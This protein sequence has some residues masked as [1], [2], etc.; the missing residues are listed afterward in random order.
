M[1]RA[2]LRLVERIEEPTGAVHKPPT[3]YS[4]IVGERPHDGLTFRQRQDE[5]VR[6]LRAV[7]DPEVK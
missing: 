5:T 7:V 2:L 6:R 3:P 4:Q 1:A